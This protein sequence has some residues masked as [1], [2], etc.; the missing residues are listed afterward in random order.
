M[1]NRNISHQYNSYS[2][3]WRNCRMGSSIFRFVGSLKGSELEY[4]DISLAARSDPWTVSS[5]GNLERQ[6]KD[7]SIAS[8]IVYLEDFCSLT[9]SEE[10]SLMSLNFSNNFVIFAL[11]LLEKCINKLIHP[12]HIPSALQVFVWKFVYRITLQSTC[13]WSYICAQG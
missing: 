3:L 12:V 4:W 8:S 11:N 1:M 13:P 9:P 10:V 6:L 2:P 7:V 5:D